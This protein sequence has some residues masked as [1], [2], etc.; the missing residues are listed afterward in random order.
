MDSKGALVTDKRVLGAIA[1]AGSL[2]AAVND[3]DF[4]FV[5]S[6]EDEYLHGSH[7][8]AEG[9]GGDSDATKRP[10]KRLADYLC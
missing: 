7:L 10:R 3:I 2:S 8:R 6:S 5:S 1:A 4:T 9:E